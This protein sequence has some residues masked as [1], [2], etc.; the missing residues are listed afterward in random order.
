VHAFNRNLLRSHMCWPCAG[1]HLCSPGACPFVLNKVSHA[2]RS[3]RASLGRWP[4]PKSDIC[5]A[6]P[7]ERAGLRAAWADV[8]GMGAST[9]GLR[10]EVSGGGGSGDHEASAGPGQCFRSLEK[11]LDSVVGMERA[12]GCQSWSRNWLLL[13]TALM[14]AVG[15]VVVWMG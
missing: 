11:S 9:S 6:L 12:A 8:V 13:V 2:S 7:A 1:S 14:L 3:V 5:E 10:Q 15:T 4:W